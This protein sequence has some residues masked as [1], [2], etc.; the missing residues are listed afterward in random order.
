M[1]KLQAL[2]IALLI[3]ILAKEIKKA[4]TSK[5]NKACIRNTINQ[6]GS[7]QQT[8]DSKGHLVKSYSVLK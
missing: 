4:S 3:I 1:N 8:F 2:K 5:A 7:H 6:Y